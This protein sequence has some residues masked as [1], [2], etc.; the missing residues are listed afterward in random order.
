MTRRSSFLSALCSRTSP[1]KAIFGSGGTKLCLFYAAA[2]RD[3]TVFTNPN[4]FDI[5]RDPNP[6]L[7]F[8]LGLHYCIGAPLARLELQTALR[9]LLTRLPNLRLVPQRL[10]VEPKNVFR[11]LKE[12]WVVY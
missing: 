7:A 1:T 5:S 11:Y 3:P 12:L 10:E 9:V 4:T 2:N 6:H 8:G